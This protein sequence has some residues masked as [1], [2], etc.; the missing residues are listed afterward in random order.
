MYLDTGP[1]GILNTSSCNGIDS[2]ILYINISIADGIG[3]IN[4]VKTDIDS[5]NISIL[6]KDNSDLTTDNIYESQRDELEL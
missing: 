4:I 2:T 6:D 3:N 5:F 1:G